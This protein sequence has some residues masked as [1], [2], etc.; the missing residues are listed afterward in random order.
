M[1]V[2][3]EGGGG[4]HWPHWGRFSPGWPLACARR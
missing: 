4:L 1:K 3:E 2:G